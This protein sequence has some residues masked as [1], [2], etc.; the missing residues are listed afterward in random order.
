MADKSLCKN[1]KEIKF[2]VRIKSFS[3]LYYHHKIHL[4]I[5]PDQIFLSEPPYAMN[6]QISYPDNQKPPDY[7]LSVYD[8]EHPDNSQCSIFLQWI[9]SVIA[10]TVHLPEKV[11]TDFLCITRRN[12]GRP[13]TMFSFDS[14]GEQSYFKIWSYHKGSTI[15]KV[16]LCGKGRVITV[17]QGASPTYS[18]FRW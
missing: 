10:H 6:C 11:C 7:K 13:L 1:V 15:R 18:A 16:S 9:K 4:K 17:S 5:Y 8:W 3:S 14:S 12:W 2:I